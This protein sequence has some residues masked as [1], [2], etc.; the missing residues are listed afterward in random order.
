MEK[1]LRCGCVKRKEN[2]IVIPGLN[3]S[4]VEYCNCP[5]PFRNLVIQ[6]PKETDDGSAILKS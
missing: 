1:C 2:V 5:S 4:P 3:E 6:P